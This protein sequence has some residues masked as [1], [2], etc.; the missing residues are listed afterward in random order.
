MAASVTRSLSDEELRKLAEGGLTEEEV[1]QISD[2][3]IRRIGALHQQ[4]QSPLAGK[5]TVAQSERAR[6]VAETPRVRTP[7]R[8]VPGPALDE[9]PKDLQSFLKS[10]GDTAHGARPEPDS[11]AN[12][13]TQ[14]WEEQARTAQ[15]PYQGTEMTSAKTAGEKLRAAQDRLIGANQPMTVTRGAGL[16]LSPEHNAAV[17]TAIQV[18][19]QEGVTSIAEFVTHPVKQYQER[20]L[21]FGLNL[22]QAALEIGP[23]TRAITGIADVIAKPKLTAGDLAVQDITAKAQFGERRLATPEARQAFNVKHKKLLGEALDLL[24]EKRSEMTPEQ[25]KQ[26]SDAIDGSVA[27]ALRANTADLTP[28]VREDMAARAV[29]DASQVSP[30]E[31]E[32]DRILSEAR[33][34]RPPLPRHEDVIASATPEEVA[35]VHGT[36]ETKL[37]EIASLKEMS[38]AVGDDASMAALRA[39]EAKIVA[40]Q[41]AIAEVRGAA[42][43]DSPYQYGDFVVTKDKGVPYQVISVEGKQVTVADMLGE[44][45]K[46][47]VDAITPNTSEASPDA[48]ERFG[49]ALSESF[50][51]SPRSTG[52]PEDLARLASNKAMPGHLQEALPVTDLP[53]APAKGAKV[54][55]ADGHTFTYV[56]EN[57][58]K[59]GK[60]G[61]RY[62]QSDKPMPLT[63]DKGRVTEE[64]IRK[65]GLRSP[66]LPL[67]TAGGAYRYAPLD[68][69][70]PVTADFYHGTKAAVAQVS[71]LSPEVHGNVGAI[72]GLGLYLTDDPSIAAGYSRTKGAGPIGKVITVRV[73]SA[74]L[75]DME[76]VA[77]PEVRAALDNLGSGIAEFETLDGP[78]T[79][80]ALVANIRKAMADSEYTTG[81]A[82]E[83]LQS[84]G[85][86]LKDLGID[87]F[88]YKGGGRVGNTPHNAL[89]LFED[90]GAGRPLRDVISD[91]PSSSVVSSQTTPA[92]GAVK[93]TDVLSVAPVGAILVAG[94][95]RD[96]QADAT[97]RQGSPLARKSLLWAGAGGIL[98]YGVARYFRAPEFRKALLN[99]AGLDEV[100]PLRTVLGPKPGRADL[101]RVFETFLSPL[102]PDRPANGLANLA[103]GLGTV[104]GAGLGGAVGSKVGQD[105]TS[106]GGAIF[107]AIAGATMGAYGG[108]NL[109]RQ[110]RT[111][112]TYRQLYKM[113]FTEAAGMSE[114][115]VNAKY[116][117]RTALE[118]RIREMKDVATELNSFDDVTNGAIQAWMSGNANISLVPVKAR[119]AAEAARRIFDNLSMDLLKSGL[120]KD[121]ILRDTIKANIGTYVPRLLL[122]YELDDPRE[123]V[124]SWLRGQGKGWGHISSKNYLKAKKDIPP[125]VLKALGEITD[126]PGY[127]LAKRGTITAADIEQARYHRFIL[128]SP[129]NAIPAKLVRQQRKVTKAQKAAI[130]GGAQVSGPPQVR[131]YRA[132]GGMEAAEWQG[133]TYWKMADN[134]RYGLVRGQYVEQ[135]VASDIIST[136]ETTSGL[137]KLFNA[138]L[139]IF[140]YFKAVMNPASQ[141]RNMT[142]NAIF[143]DIEAGI[144]P[145]RMDKWG[146]GL[147]DLLSKGKWYKQ[148]R[149]DGVFGGEFT[150][151]EIG[152]ML[153]PKIKS[154]SSVMHVAANTV[155]DM[156]NKPPSWFTRWHQ[157]SEAWARLTVYRHAVE[158]LGMEG[159]AAAKFARRTIPDYQDVP[160]W[161]KVV[162]TSPFGAPFISFSYKAL[163]RSLEAAVSFGDPKKMMRFWKY[164]L[165]MAALNE[166]SAQTLGLLGKDEERD[167]F[168]TLRRTVLRTLSAGTYSPDSYDTFRKYLPNH[169]GKMQITIPWRDQYDRPHYLDGTF[170]LPWGDAGE[171]GKGDF[172]KSIGADWFP[173][174]L[175]PS[176]PWFQLGV[177]AMTGKDSFTGRDIVPAGSVGMEHLMA[178]A[179]FLMRAWG[180][181]LLNPAGYSA[182]ALSK[183]F[184]GRFA[185]DPNVKSRG[186]AV[187]S[188]IMGARTRPVDPRT[189]YRFK[190]FELKRDLESNM[191]ELR[192]LIPALMKEEDLTSAQVK[193][194]LATRPGEAA[195][196]A[197]RRRLT[198][199]DK[200]KKK[201]PAEDLPPTPEKL[202]R[203]IQEQYVH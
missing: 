127:L 72:K 191:A 19:L 6:T 138:P 148:A 201:Y 39:S 96:D 177:A 78:Q 38:R 40:A 64:M 175:E 73:N 14:S 102:F 145:Y 164:P 174:Q 87:G 116:M 83:V 180:P 141:F 94:V 30:Q 82:T 161:L 169:V 17:A 74:N 199:V 193:Q 155:I 86:E 46:F 123:L 13:Q 35:A 66:S 114:S 167:V 77:A 8:T 92:R 5:P 190:Y 185:E 2:D 144:A 11:A 68:T 134:P 194:V 108:A 56:G 3:D 15:N 131:F 20:P 4:E 146:N 159:P 60:V 91:A 49:A 126:N 93:L 181:S 43:A 154:E 158:S 85:V 143:A 156:A 80:G 79:V 57:V 76:S 202:A 22:L 151:S 113:Y 124:E 140:K 55:T 89:V 171:M 112:L 136:H 69:S 12:F 122:R 103:P 105:E 21:E 31:A 61:S 81:D 184:S 95:A 62:W 27:K 36:L 26:A 160:R 129:E 157:G 197:L 135:A 23:A 42:G 149:N 172:A 119:P 71:E 196:R 24:E 97:P 100:S 120:V 50:D 84:L 16:S 186:T 182:E 110:F 139:S 170:F 104:A 150:V 53:P 118:G 200:F 187:A 173:R 153:L 192:R 48:M 41:D 33:A 168:G 166:Y 34:K 163:P 117:T 107:G 51:N 65:N 75:L 203:A 32:M 45:S 7:Q 165:A 47:H 90:F 106:P 142:S 29:Q 37:D 198:L 54:T 189:A 101:E 111:P 176:N 67:E 18:G 98:A 188:E 109:A 28:A 152:D 70:T 99:F 132:E 137:Q 9:G 10:I 130:A 88:R 63:R 128:S 195:S 178:Q 162:R 183:S 1:A 179:Q 58:G 147:N 25:W 133:R 115:A 121:Q 52:L 44:R 59:D 125:D